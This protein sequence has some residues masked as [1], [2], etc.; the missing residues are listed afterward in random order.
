MGD[1]AFSVETV[2]G[3]V[4]LCVLHRSHVVCDAR[5]GYDVC[6]HH[7]FRVEE[8]L[9]T[10]QRKRSTWHEENI[11]RKHNYIPFIFNLLRAAAEEGKLEPFIQRAQRV[12]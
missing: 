12:A 10:E 5:G 6:S 8:E 3:F 7:L 11:R 9:A 2:V 4:A 1:G